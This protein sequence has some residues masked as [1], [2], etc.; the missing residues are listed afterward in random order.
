MATQSEDKA[1]SSA[2]PVQAAI[3]PAVTQAFP[4]EEKM[5]ADG[6]A[7]A[8]QEIDALGGCGY[9]HSCSGCHETNE[10]H[11]TG[12]YPYSKIFNCY[13]GSGCHECGGIGVIW[14]HHTADMLADLG[15]ELDARVTAD[16]V[17]AGTRAQ[18]E[19]SLHSSLLSQV[20]V[21]TEALE[22]IERRT[23][24]SDNEGVVE[25]NRIARK[26]LGLDPEPKHMFVPS[27]QHMGD[28]RVC[29]NVEEAP[30]HFART[31]LSAQGEKTDG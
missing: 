31:A 11:E 10:G 25:V 18:L 19:T 28:C 22:K 1:V 5:L 16:S 23:C 9:W 30:Q 4:P 26:A 27:A 8:V 2:L 21:L 7:E 13:L 24:L 6:V 20:S 12:W 17:P 15:Q 3:A 14:D 29:G